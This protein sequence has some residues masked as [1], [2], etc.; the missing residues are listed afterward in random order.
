MKP[1]Y[2]NAPEMVISA[3]SRIAGTALGPFIMGEKRVDLDALEKKIMEQA[4]Y[5]MGILVYTIATR[6]EPYVKLDVDDY[7]PIKIVIVQPETEKKR[8]KTKPKAKTSN[9]T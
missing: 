4:V 2:G 6:L 7:Q 9:K 3:A 8:A 5:E 1:N